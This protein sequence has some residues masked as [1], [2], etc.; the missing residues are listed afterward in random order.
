MRFRYNGNRL[1]ETEPA[2]PGIQ[3]YSVRKEFES[4]P[5]QTLRELSSMGYKTVEFAGF[6]NI[7][8]EIMNRYL[9][10]AVL[11]APSAHIPYEDLIN[12]LHGQ[13]NYAK[14]IG[15]QYI[16]IPW[17]DPSHLQNEARLHQLSKSLKEIAKNII[18][19]GLQLAYHNHLEEFE[20]LPTGEL[21]I[22]RLLDEVGNNMK[23]EIDL[24][25]TYKAGFSLLEIL[26]K[27]KGQV[28][29]V[30]IKEMNEEGETTELN[31]G[32]I[33]YRFVLKQ[34]ERFG[35]DYY[36]VEQEHFSRPPLE[37][38]KQNSDFIKKWRGRNRYK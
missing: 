3:L 17:M 2:P 10:D 5:L 26:E 30:H 13:I 38:A 24:Y 27:Y 20:R 21:I 25:W 12:D 23:L 15:L 11:K 37:S 16:V 9:Q 32:V 7:P 1:S 33:D 8:A 19:A 4:Q 36:F 18:D 22:D 14:V 34:L 6:Y 29:L 28:P 31:H 35:V